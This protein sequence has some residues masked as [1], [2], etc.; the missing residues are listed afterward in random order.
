M[1]A[2][3]FVVI[4][5]SRNRFAGADDWTAE[6]DREWREM[7]ARMDNIERPDF[8]ERTLSSIVRRPL[9][10]ASRSRTTNDGRLTSDI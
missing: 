7:L 6:Q 3:I 4:Y 2:G 8:S 5:R 10:V 1:F 9:S